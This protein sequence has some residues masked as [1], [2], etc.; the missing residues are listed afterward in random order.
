MKLIGPMKK[1]SIVFLTGLSL[2][3]TGCGSDPGASEPGT[4][5][6]DEDITM[7]APQEPDSTNQISQTSDSSS[8]GGNVKS[9]VPGSDNPRKVDI[10]GQPHQPG[11]PPDSINRNNR[12]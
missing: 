12:K 10:G 8:R 5:A 1:L 4:G 7:T 3:L 2:I 6:M 11:P 9:T